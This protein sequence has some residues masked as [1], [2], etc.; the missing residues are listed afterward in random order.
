MTFLKKFIK[1]KSNNKGGYQ[2]YVLKRTDQGGGY[3]AKDGY[4]SSYVS[5]RGIQ[6]IKKFATILEA[7]KERCVDNEIILDLDPLIM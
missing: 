5:L 6:R 2:M 3:V 4:K 1:I 7:E